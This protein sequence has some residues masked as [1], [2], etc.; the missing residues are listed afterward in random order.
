MD[1]F[2]ASRKNRLVELTSALR[3]DHP[4]IADENGSTPLVVASYYNSKEAVALL[5]SVGANPDVHDRLGNTA[6][7]GASF[8]GNIAIVALLLDGGARIDQQNDN[9]A[10]ALTFA[11]IFGHAEIVSLLLKKGADPLIRDRFGKTAADYASDHDNALCYEML[12][13]ATNKNLNSDKT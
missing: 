2:E 12:A 7:M 3:S 9:F 6:L 13:A 10:T 1:I 4:D 5:L 8:K 11:A